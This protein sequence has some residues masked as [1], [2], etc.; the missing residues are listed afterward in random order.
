MIDFIKLDISHDIE[1]VTNNEGLA[2][3]RRIAEAT[4]EYKEYVSAE[5]KNILLKLKKGRYLELEGSIHKY[6]NDG[7]HNHN[8]FGISE[9]SKS[10]ND[11][12]SNIRFDPS[13]ARLRNIEFGVNITVPYNA[14][15][16]LKH[17]L[18]NFKGFPK[19][20]NGPYK[21]KGWMVEFEQ[22]SYLIKF[23]DK[24]SH[25]DLCSNILRFE[26][27]TR[28]MEYIKS[29]EIRTL[30]DLTDTT[31]I[32]RLIPILLNAFDKL[33]IYDKADESAL[34]PEDLSIFLH[35]INAD[36]WSQMK[37]VRSSTNSND[38]VV[39]NPKY[40]RQQAAYK[41]SFSRFN[42]MLERN[43]LNRTKKDL[44][45]LIKDKYDQLIKV[46]TFEGW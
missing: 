37:P 38:Q 25:Y 46:D 36:W 18:I 19:T 21:G 45:E 12:S 1:N 16:F 23:Y 34:S 30:S 14:T 20:K 43:N 11:L 40:R 32:V 7:Q 2:F 24:G 10:I 35:G 9:I 41:K 13:S 8:D 4:G 22:T 27:R 33:L 28:R 5:H 26:I 3:Y 44:S 39:F 6:F 17:Q 15:D 31:K 42:D 29:T